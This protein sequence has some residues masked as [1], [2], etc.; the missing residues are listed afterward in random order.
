M[1]TKIEEYLFRRIFDVVTIPSELNRI[2]AE[3]E[4]KGQQ[5]KRGVGGSV[6]VELTDGEVHFIPSG[7]G[8]ECI[9]YRKNN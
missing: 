7:R 4:K 2:A 6:I 5:V 9:I 1:M 8:I 3:E